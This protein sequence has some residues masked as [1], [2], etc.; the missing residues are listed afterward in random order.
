MAL[1]YGSVFEAAFSLPPPLGE[2]VVGF[3]GG[4]LV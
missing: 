3:V 1:V 2:K 4:F